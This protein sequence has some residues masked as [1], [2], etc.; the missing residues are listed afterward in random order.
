MSRYTKHTLQGNEKILRVAKLHWV[1]YSRALVFFLLSIAVGITAYVTPVG[2]NRLSLG[3]VSA[4]LLL[5]A[6]HAVAALWRQLTTELAITDRRVIY[7]TG[8]IWRK[9]A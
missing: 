4:L 7:K 9:T 5:S 6:K 8:F 3:V 2:V 1:I